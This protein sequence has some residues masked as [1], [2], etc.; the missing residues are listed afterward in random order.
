MQTL[1]GRLHAAGAASLLQATVGTMLQLLGT[2]QSHS[3]CLPVGDM[4]L[5]YCRSVTQLQ[6]L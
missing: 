3:R 1:S 5:Q 2:D 6:P 4:L